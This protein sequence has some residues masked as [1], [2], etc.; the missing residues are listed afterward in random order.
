MTTPSH[1]KSVT[2]SLISIPE[3][4]QKSVQLIQ[5][6]MRETTDQAHLLFF[7]IKSSW[8]TL[9]QSGQTLMFNPCRLRTV[10]LASDSNAVS[11]QIAW[12]QAGSS[13]LDC[14]SHMHS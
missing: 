14:Y 4:V 7:V 3:L 11:Q 2:N 8:L 12:V 9:R 5:K 6:H 1:P 10:L 13:V